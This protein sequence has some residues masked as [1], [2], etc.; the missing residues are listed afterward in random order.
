[1][2]QYCSWLKGFLKALWRGDQR[3]QITAK[4]KALTFLQRHT[5]TSGWRDKIKELRVSRQPLKSYISLLSQRQMFQNEPDYHKE[6]VPFIV[7]RRKRSSLSEHTVNKCVLWLHSESCDP[8]ESDQWVFSRARTWP[9]ASLSQRSPTGSHHCNYHLL[10]STNCTSSILLSVELNRTSAHL[11]PLYVFRSNK[12][13]WFV[14]F[15]SFYRVILKG[16]I[17]ERCQVQLEVDAFRKNKPI[18]LEP[19]ELFLIG[20]LIL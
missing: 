1:M 16:V 9:L 20:P 5:E 10:V 2:V 13:L 15:S 3:K 7:C 19:K 6:T 12:E 11:I 4:V 14:Y 18:G 8:E 17:A